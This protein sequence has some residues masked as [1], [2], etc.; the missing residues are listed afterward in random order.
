MDPLIYAC[1]SCG[2]E[3]SLDI[4]LA[5]VLEDLETRGLVEDVLTDGVPVGAQL[6]RYVRLHKPP[7]HQLTIARVRKILAE[8]VPDIRRASIERDGRIVV[9]TPA[10]WQAAF[11]A[12][13]TAVD[14]GTLKRP[15]ASNNYLY[16]V[17]LN[18]AEAAAAAA[19]TQREEERRH[20][21]KRDTVT[22]DGQSMDIGTALGVVYGRVDPAIAKIESDSAKAAPV[23]A[24]VRE[25]RDRLKG[26][27]QS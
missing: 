21:G 20:G 25:M 4:V 26:G 2:A 27:S 12:V 9:A 3:V 1:V 18:Q 8:L 14:R 19:E 7:K 13:F 16:S 22:V 17:L 15:L 10:H 23:P 11:E 24:A 5:R 6:A